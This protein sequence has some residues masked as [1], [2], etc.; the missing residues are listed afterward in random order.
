[1]V[2]ARNAAIFREFPDVLFGMVLNTFKKPSVKCIDVVFD[3]YGIEDSIKS[4]VRVRSGS[5]ASIS[6]YEFMKGTS[7]YQI[8]GRKSSKIRKTKQI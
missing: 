7:S 5:E 1:M 4:F 8:N 3:R 2:K 6:K